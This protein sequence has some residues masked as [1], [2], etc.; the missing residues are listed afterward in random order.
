L[1]TVLYT[2]S[3]TFPKRH[4]VEDLLR[5][6]QPC[7]TYSLLAAVA[8]ALLARFA[9]G[10][11]P[12]TLWLTGLTGAGK[13]FLAKLFMN[14][15]GDFPV[16]SGRFAAWSA[17]AN[18]LQRQGYF[19]RDCLYLVD[20]YKPEV[21]LHYQVV[22]V[23]QN[24]ADRT[25]RGRL[26]VD[27]TTNTTR[28]VRGLMVSTGE[29]VPEHTASA[30]ARSIVIDV[31]QQAKDLERGARCV[32]AS[33]GYR[34]VTADFI[35]HLLAQGRTQSFAA[36][37]SA[38]RQRYYQDIAGQQNDS[39]IAGNFALLAAAFAEAAAYFQDVWPGW[40]K[41]AERFLEQDLVA[42]RDRMLGAV[43]EQQ[44][45]EV[46][47]TVLGTLVHNKAVALGSFSEATKGKPVVGKAIAQPPVPGLL[48]I[49]TDLAL[50][51]VNQC[52]RAQGRPELKVSHATL[53]GQLRREG[54]L[55]DETGRPLSPDGDDTPTRQPRIDGHARRS[56]LTT[57]DLLAQS[58]APQRSVPQQ[59][60]E[61]AEEAF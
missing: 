9:P 14:F 25:G 47:W 2:A 23:L 31:P 51:A 5:L 35:Q 40:E 7:V 12:F 39:R 46:F 38:L 56:F 48:F 1:S 13:S 15:F 19:F 22:R 54:R 45:S 55:L 49:S 30:V 34:A 32:D 33:P 42:A 53:L 11:D 61:Q 20:D 18:Y 10:A 21:V 60:P 43:R 59:Q 24:Y 6:H 4:I 8:A 37:V 44:A 3:E 41:E 58:L 27:A 29:D 28:P 57:Y 50:A 17:T 26:K 36:S 52:L 16:A